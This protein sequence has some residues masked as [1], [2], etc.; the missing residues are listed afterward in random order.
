MKTKDTPVLILFS[1]KP[2]IVMK[3]KLLF[4][5]LILFTG[6]NLTNAQTLD[7]RLNNTPTSCLNSNT[8]NKQGQSFTCGISG[9]LSRIKLNFSS[10]T[11]FGSYTLKI[12]AGDGTGGTL[13]GSKTL[14]IT[15][16]GIQSFNL[17]PSI[18]VV[19][20]SMYTFE[21][22]T[23]TANMCSAVFTGNLYTNGKRYLNGTGSTTIDMWFE[24]YVTAAGTNLTQLN[25][26]QCDQTV[27]GLGGS[28]YC[29][30]VTNAQDYQ[31]RFSGGNL[32]N[33]VTIQRNGPWANVPRTNVPGI[34]EGNTYNVEVRARLSNSWQP[35]GSI[36]Q[37]TIAAPTCQLV[38]G[39]CN[40]TETATG[41]LYC[42]AV[43]G[44]TNYKFR[45][46]D[47]D[48]TTPIEIERTGP[49]K[50]FN[51][52]T[53]PMHVGQL[54]TVEVTAKTN[55]T[56]L[57]YGTPCLVEITSMM[58]SPE[59]LLRFAQTAQE[60]NEVWLEN[61]FQVNVYPNPSGATGFDINVSGLSYEENDILVDIYDIYGKLVTSE[62]IQ[63][64]GNGIIGKFNANQTLA[65][66]VYLLNVTI[67]GQTKTEKIIVE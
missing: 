2:I 11:S 41:Y 48:L 9:N 17:A 45:I 19:A 28:F 1:T 58:N 25:S 31:F 59:D 61:E 50:N 30:L 20:G 26:T 14:T 54:Y 62:K 51:K 10:I 38:A 13:L 43:D 55:G 29:D 18:P 65:A 35:F 49:Y 34:A 5:G 15:N 37:I 3:V 47:G 24:T 33:P 23:T 40:Q 66:G 32:T 64:N 60:Q 67:N 52:A 12:F 7:Q 39:D 57:P 16:T 21:L 4:S 22:N 63:N 53:V 8:S 36:C 46:S 56:Y 6:I 42:T 27:I 44:A